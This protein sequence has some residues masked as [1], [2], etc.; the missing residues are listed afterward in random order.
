VTVFRLLVERS[1]RVVPG[2][3][4]QDLASYADIADPKGLPILVAA[5][6][7]RC[8]WLV[9][10]NVDDFVPGHPD[11]TVL[12]PGAFI[13]RVRAILAHMDLTGD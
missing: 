4:R 12:R 6:R 11:V 7:E 8:E 13:Q 10:F 5:I 9:A 1:L 3:S 2:P